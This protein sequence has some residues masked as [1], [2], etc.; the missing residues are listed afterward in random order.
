MTTP[1][2]PVTA[3]VSY[4]NFN[5]DDAPT[6][7]KLLALNPGNVACFATITATNRKDFKAWAPLPKIPKEHK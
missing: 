4:Y 6:G 5:M 1:N 3:H 2:D 7:R